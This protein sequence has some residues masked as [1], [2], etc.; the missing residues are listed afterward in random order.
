M[1]N[2]QKPLELKLTGT[3]TYVPLLEGP[4]RTKGLRS[5]RVR[6][7]PGEDVGVHSTKAHEEIVLFLEGIGT[8]T[9]ENAEDFEAS[10]GQ[11]VYVLPHTEHNITNKGDTVLKYVFVVAPVVD[12]HD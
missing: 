1:S 10:V 6:L 3:E 9:S 12:T 11:A 5:G 2:E 8:V 7:N 4:P